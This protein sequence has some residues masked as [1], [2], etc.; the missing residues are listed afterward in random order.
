MRDV[1]GLGDGLPLLPAD[2]VDRPGLGHRRHRRHGRAHRGRPPAAHSRRSPAPS[3]RA[4]AGLQVGG[5]LAYLGGRV[6]GQY[7]PSAARTAAAGCCSWRP[8][9]YA[10]QQALNVPSADF[11]MWVCL[12]EATHRL[13]FTAVPWLRELLRAGGRPVP[14]DGRRHAA[15]R[16]LRAA[17]RSAVSR[18]P[19]LGRRLARARRAAAGPRAARRAGPAARAHHP[20]R[21]PRGPRHGRRRARTSCRV[22]RRSGPGSPC[23]A[24]AAGSSTGSCARCWASR[25]RSSS[26]RW[27]RRSQ[28]RRARGGDGRVQ[29]GLGVAGDPADPRRAGRPRVLAAPASPRLTGFTPVAGP[30]SPGRGRERSRRPAVAAVRRAVRRG[31]RRASRAGARRAAA[32]RVLRRGRLHRPARR[33]PRRRARARCTS[34]SSTTGCRTARPSAAPPSSPAL[35]AQGVPAAVH[36]VD[37]DGPGGVEA[38]A[39]RRPL[40]RPAR[41]PPAPGLGRPA[42]PHPRR[43]GRD[44]AAR[45]RPRLGS[46]VAGRHDDLGPAVAAVRC[47][48]CAGRTPRPR[49]ARRT[50]RS[51]TTRTTPTPASPASGCATRCC[52]CSRRC[53][54]AASPRRWPA[55]PRSCA[56]TVRRSTPPRTTCSPARTGTQKTPCRNARLASAPSTPTSSA[57]RPPPSAGGRCAP[58]SPPHGVTG[59]TDLHLRAAD[60]LVGRWRGQGA[61]ALPQR[62]ELV[63]ERGRLR[64]RTA[65]WPGAR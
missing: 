55:P 61:V 23:A 25:R 2:V 11:G 3:P 1:T 60:D 58:G 16:V 47:W 43:P 48:A 38:A 34:P 52:R 27:A 44:R 21:G 24:A 30:R 63:R 45:P 18:D 7:D 57:P 28:V 9:V 5:V 53:S 31:A 59:L 15:A 10:A 20:A 32:R 40:R 62:L 64:V 19:R 56:T 37:V 4:T 13:Q 51:G 35:T 26:T 65:A 12:H 6:L 54:A 42:R 49:A 39:R 33:R 46:P 29:P 36:T 41:R 17:A 22:S 14:V 8:N 50:C